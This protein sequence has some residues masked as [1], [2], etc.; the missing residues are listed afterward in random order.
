M[1]I[2]MARALMDAAVECDEDPSVRC[3]IPAALEDVLCRRRCS[4]V[5][6]GRRPYPSSAV[7]ADQPPSL[8]DLSLGYT[9][10]LWDRSLR[11]GLEHRSGDGLGDDQ[12]TRP[13]NYDQQAR[14][15][16]NTGHRASDV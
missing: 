11:P 3:L 10:L 16:Q 9:A 1:D 15:L 14:H 4:P 8:G 12:E 5:L 13:R 2:A 6:D 7:G